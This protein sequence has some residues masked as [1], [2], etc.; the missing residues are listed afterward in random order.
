MSDKK[1]IYLSAS[2]I[3]T[4]QQCSWIYWCKYILKLPD[5]SNDG[6][7]KGWICHLIFEV[8]GKDRRKPYFDKIIKD[9]TAF[10]IKSIKKLITKHAIKLN[11]N[12]KEHLEDMDRMIVRGLDYD[13][14]GEEG[15]EIAKAFSEKE[16]NISVDEGNV[17]Y[18]IRGFIDKLF[19]YK[20]NSAVIRDFKTSKQKFKGKEISDNMQDL[21]YCL[22]IK[23]LFPEYKSLS[24]FLF[25]KFELAKDILGEPGDGVIR[26]NELS[27]D[28]LEGF[29]LE[30]SSIQNYLE[31]FDQDRAQSNFASD[32][33]YPKDGTFGGPLC[34][35]KDG[36]KMCRGE[37]VKDESGK[38]IKAFI[39]QFRK[40][41]KYAVLLDSENKFKK[42]VF[43]EDK[44]QLDE[45]KEEGDSIE[46]REYE[47]CP[48]WQSNEKFEL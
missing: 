33:G 37:P 21:M 23:K 11:V 14:F 24:E 41:F 42:S 48:A 22:A 32:Q 45:I 2:R 19:L 28:V 9:K 29:E 27:D 26:M 17:K 20:N 4:A 18:N 7:S 15:G 12:T 30:L 8:L 46:I 16:F 38:P 3:K 5:K 31:T 44:E 39:C 1:E 34:C 40:A 35:G 25:L 36:F 13:F 6:A 43:Y 10:K 47:G